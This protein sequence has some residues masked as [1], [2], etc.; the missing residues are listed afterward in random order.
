[1]TI[2]GVCVLDISNSVPKVYPQVPNAT[3]EFVQNGVGYA[4]IRSFD[5]SMAVVL[6]PNHPPAQIPS[7]GIDD[8]TPSLLRSSQL[9]RA[10]RFSFERR[11]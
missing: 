11:T 7:S 4:R 6:L 10:A 2:S 9:P 1:M 8:P 5:Y 3:P